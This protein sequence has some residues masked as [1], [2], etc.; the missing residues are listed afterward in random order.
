MIIACLLCSQLSVMIPVVRNRC[1]ASCDKGESRS[2]SEPDSASL[3]N[4]EWSPFLRWRN[5]L[6]M[7]K[8]QVRA[9]IGLPGVV[10]DGARREILQEPGR[11]YK[12]L[13]DW[14]GDVGNHNCID[15]LVWESEKPIVVMRFR[16]WDGAKGLYCGRAT[17]E[18]GGEPLV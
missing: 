7:V 4:W 18:R 8:Q 10:E 14:R 2:A 12:V 3:R 11:P 15:G 1:E 5:L 13:M 16:N 6:P 17:V 9:S